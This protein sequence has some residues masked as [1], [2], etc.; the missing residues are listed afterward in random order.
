[1]RDAYT[2]RIL[3]KMFMMFKILSYFGRGIKVYRVFLEKKSA[4]N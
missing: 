4:P 1:M 2:Q 3:I